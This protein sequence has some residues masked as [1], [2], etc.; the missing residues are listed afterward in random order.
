MR[1]RGNGIASLL[2]GLGGSGSGHLRSLAGRADALLRDLPAGRYPPQ[3]ESNAQPGHP[4]T[5]GE[6]AHS[7]RFNRLNRGYDLTTASPLAAAAQAAYTLHPISQVPAD[8]FKVVGGLL[9]TGVNGNPR[10]LTNIDR[11]NVSPRL[12][13]AYALSP[14]TAIRAGYGHFYGGT[15]AQD[16]TNYGFSATTTWVTSINGVTPVDTLSNP[17]PNGISQPTG[18]AAGLLTSVGQGITYVNPNRNQLWTQ[19]VSV[20]IQRQL[21]GNLVLDAMYG[22]TRTHDYPVTVS[23]DAIPRQYQLQARQSYVQTGLNI[24]SASASNPFY[25]LI[26]SGSLSGTTTTVG[27]LLRPYPQ[28]TGISASGQN[29]GNTQYDS[30]QTK[31]NKRLA[32]GLSFLVSYTISKAIEATSYLND[33]D[34]TL[35]RRLSTWDVPQ[36]LV[37]SGSYQLPVGKGKPLLRNSSGLVNKLAGGWQMNWVYTAESGVPLAISSGESLGRTAYLPK[38]ERTLQRWFDTS[39][40]RLRETLEFAGTNILP[41]V[42]SQGRNNLDLSLY[43]DTT[44]HESLKLQFRAES[45]NLCNRTEFGSP[46]TTVGST[47]FGV[48]S[49]QINFGRQLQF[50]LRLLW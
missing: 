14:K 25:G 46:N 1:P 39:A 47:S 24:L 12:G 3:L 6:G 16:T 15:T 5:S 13:I 28:F 11:D 7:E 42:R 45:F 8:Q 4:V 35:Y 40:F 20:S 31:L 32:G 18:S 34:T 9:F 49:S 10:G 27:Q 37:L 22:G 26:S 21:P 44:I 19:Q 38:G 29:L 41:D 30:F 23:A 17:F 43:K 50:A 36:R 48:T 33:T 2:L